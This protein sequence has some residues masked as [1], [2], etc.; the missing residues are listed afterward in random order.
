VLRPFKAHLLSSS[1]SSSAVAAQ[2]AAHRPAAELGGL[3]GGA[4]R[5]QQELTL[6][7]PEVE[8]VLDSREFDILVDVLQNVC[9][10][11]LPQVGGCG[12]GGVGGWGGG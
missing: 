8:G 12:G 11:A 4:T 2:A 6:E 9:G 7:V 3:P 1:L 5:A 10:G